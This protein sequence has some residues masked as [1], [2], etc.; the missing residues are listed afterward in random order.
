L[1]P[2]LKT[3]TEL[4]E[5]DLEIKSINE[6]QEEAPKRLNALKE[7]AAEKKEAYKELNEL[8]KD[9][10]RKKTELEDELEMEKIRLAKCQARLTQLKTNREYQALMK[11]IEEIKRSGKEREDEVLSLME[12]SEKNSN[13]MNAIKDEIEL[14][15]KEIVV[16]EKNLQKV[17]AKLN[18]SLNQIQK[19]RNTITKDVKKELLSRYDFLKEKRAGLAVA[20]VKNQACDGCHMNIPHQLY[21]ELLRNEKI[22]FCPVCQRIIYVDQESSE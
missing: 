10:H 8:F 5:I 1:L 14:L 16:E 13:E 17:E 15:K 12:E 9:I 18:K 2:E 21:N 7:K 11:E 3:L 4:Q 6:K 20:L 22:H 19:K